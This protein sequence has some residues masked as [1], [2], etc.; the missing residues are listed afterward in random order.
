MDDTAAQPGWIL[1][2]VSQPS[3]FARARDALLARRSLQAALFI[4]ILAGGFGLL[5]LPA[6][7]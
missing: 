1:S 2:A 3:L 7:P 5:I 6:P 4:A